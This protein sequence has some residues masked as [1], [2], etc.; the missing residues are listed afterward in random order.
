MMNLFKFRRENDIDS[1]NHITNDIDPYEKIG[2]IVKEARINNDLSVED[3][4]TIS[5]IPISTINAIENNDKEL[6]PQ[7]PFLRSKLLKLEECLSIKSNTLTKLIKKN[8]SPFKPKS[9]INLIKNLDFN[10]S[11]SGSIAYLLILLISIL[12]LNRYYLNSRIIEF[13]YINLDEKNK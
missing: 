13:K 8:L 1:K 5:L 2:K 6:I 9:R 4:S 3:L 7:Y 11:L 10:K 12:I